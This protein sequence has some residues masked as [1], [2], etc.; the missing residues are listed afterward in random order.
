MSKEDRD[1]MEKDLTF[2]EKVI[3]LQAEAKVDK[4]KKGNN[5]KYTF[6]YRDKDS[7]LSVIK[8]VLY[9]LGLSL[10]NTHDII[11]LEGRIFIKCSAILTDG[12]DQIESVA[13]A[14]L[15]NS[16]LLKGAQ[17]TGSTITYAERYAL[18]SLLLITT[19]FPEIEKIAEGADIN[20]SLNIKGDK[21]IV[22]TLDE[23]NL[24][25]A[26]YQFKPLYERYINR[27]AFSDDDKKKLY[28]IY[29][30]SIDADK[31]ISREKL[32]VKAMCDS[33]IE[34]FGL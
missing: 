33:L 22:K 14:E 2:W 9:N 24:E 30:N 29:M 6:P 8:P 27:M 32:G 3:K 28:H 34:R 5:G 25:S 15:E 10:R 18:C 13:F 26:K 20:S 4:D 11:S 23:M 7:I 21:K 19:D 17:L 12:V 1:K 31:Q 16:A